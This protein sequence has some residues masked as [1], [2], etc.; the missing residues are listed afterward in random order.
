MGIEHRCGT[1]RKT[2][3]WCLRC[4]LWLHCR[5]RYSRR[6]NLRERR[7]WRRLGGRRMLT[8]EEGYG[9]CQHEVGNGKS[10]KLTRDEAFWTI[11]R[12]AQRQ[13]QQ[14]SLGREGRSSISASTLPF[15]QYTCYSSRHGSSLLRT[16]DIPERIPWGP[17]IETMS[18]RVPE[19]PPLLKG[20]LL[21]W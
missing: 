7:D 15:A 5:E 10:G 16:H 13:R 2:S 1:G 20:R 4:N 14:R 21:S 8:V 12:P 6:R 11:Q 3:L 17:L 9:N 18:R 19:R